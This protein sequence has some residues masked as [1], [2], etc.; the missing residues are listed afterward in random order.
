MTG[1]VSLWLEH[2]PA[3]R[4]ALVGPVSADV[5]IVGAGFTGLWTALALL[6]IDPTLDVVV[7]EAETV[8]F[9]GSGRN[10]GFV[11]PSL[12]H[13]LENG[14]AHHADEVDELVRLGLDNHAGLVATVRDAGIDCALEE[15]GA[16]DV[17]TAPWQLE[18]LAASA[19]L[20]RRHGLGARLLDRDA[21]RAELDSPTYLGGVAHPEVA[22]V[23]PGRLVRGLAELAV[24]RGGRL[25][26]GTPVT[27]LARADGR[28]ELVTP[29]GRVR[30]ERAVLATNAWTHRLL[31]R[32][33]RRFVPVYDHV[34]V[35][36]PLTSEQRAR[37]GWSRRQGFSD[38][39]NRFH[40]YRLTRDDRI[41]WGGYDANY[42]FG[43]SVG[44]KHDHHPV[45]MALLEHNFR[46]TFPQLAD[47]AFEH[48][49]G[50]PIATTT[51]FMAT[52]GSALGGRVEFA[53]G[54]TGLGVAASR[55]AGRVLAAGI[56][57]PGSPLR[58]LAFTTSRPFP[59]P[60]EPLRWLAV[61]LTRRALIRADE[62]E[63]RR[64]PWLRSLDRLGV[65]FDS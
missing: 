27:A 3:P 13:G 28:V 47:V 6:E 35:T 32:T 4:A 39:G 31:R 29:G 9:G 17:A 15:V 57:E 18:E 2:P 63:G 20:H 50:G 12:T 52:F 55:F 14:I 64:G 38:S 43:S 16:I 59:F 56:L 51:D 11:D 60:P 61:N 46:A 53:L 23:D 25:Y 22:L 1:V 41:L 54:Y 49:W 58:Q 65:G 10:G 36:A 48:R 5:A 26:E 8:G 37:I 40:Y 44:P 33:R 24:A 30:A 34:L 19:E 42:H 21:V 7:L 62:R 45:T